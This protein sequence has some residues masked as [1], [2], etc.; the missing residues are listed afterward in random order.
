MVYVLCA[1]LL[2]VGIFGLISQKNVIKIII[3]ISIMENAVNLF[4][5]VIG[6]RRGGIAPI[7]TERIYEGVQFAEK[8]V[9]PLPQA[10]VLTSIVIG[11]G[12]MAL[13]VTMALR[14]YHVHGTY[15]ITEILKSRK[16][17]EQ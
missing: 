14:I 10:M 15:D 12:V 16:K 9:D 7:I 8:A 4:L 6:Y 2:C 3:S 11:L 13:M 5:V 1:M 17:A